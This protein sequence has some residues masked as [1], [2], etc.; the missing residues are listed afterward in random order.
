MDNRFLPKIGDEANQVV[1]SGQKKDSDLENQEKIEDRER[2]LITLRDEES[3]NLN[4]DSIYFDEEKKKEVI[5]DM[6]WN[7]IIG[8]LRENIQEGTLLNL[9]SGVVGAHHGLASADRIKGI[10]Y[11]DIE[12]GN[13]QAVKEF[14]LSIEGDKKSEY[15]EEQDIEIFKTFAEALVKDEKHNFK[16]SGEQLMTE[17]LEKSKHK[18]KLDIIQCDMLEQINQLSSGELVDGRT[19]DNIQ[20]SFA[21]FFLNY[22]KDKEGNYFNSDGEGN[23][24]RYEDR[25]NPERELF[26]KEK[27]FEYIEGI[28]KIDITDVD[29]LSKLIDKEKT[30]EE[31]IK[32]FEKIKMRLNKGGKLIILDG[33]SYDGPEEEGGLSEGN[34]V[35]ELYGN[36][37]DWTEEEM[38]EFLRKAGFEIKDNEQSHGFHPISSDT[39]GEKEKFGDGYLYFVAKKE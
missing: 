27:V 26:S 28:E 11:L 7:Y 13:N 15:L 31:I 2:V 33:K 37:Y 10:T 23:F 3:N 32:F 24:Y 35:N 19:Y 6:D 22:Y 1:S 21:A 34:K 20:M 16:I 8:F 29:N 30:Y 17:L 39:P 14:L 25:N 36:T 12:E 5:D 18:E 4:E 38:V 9:G